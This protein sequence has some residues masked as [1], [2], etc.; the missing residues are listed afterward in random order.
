MI[1]LFSSHF[2]LCTVPSH[3]Q[4]ASPACYIDVLHIVNIT[5]PHGIGPCNLSRY[6]VSVN[7]GLH[8]VFRTCNS[9][10]DAKTSGMRPAHSSL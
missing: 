8:F 3:L 5:R 10:L 6:L 4:I 9:A 7:V 2:C 1:F